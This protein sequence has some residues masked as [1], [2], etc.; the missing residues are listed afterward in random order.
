[1]SSKVQ[2]VCASLSS[3]SLSSG[4]FNVLCLRG[5]T[6]R[7]VSLMFAWINA[8]LWHFHMSDRKESFRST[9][10]DPPNWHFDPQHLHMSHDAGGSCMFHC[11]RRGQGR[12]WAITEQEFPERRRGW[13]KPGKPPESF[14]L[15]A[16]SKRNASS[17]ALISENDLSLIVPL[18]HPPAAERYVDRAQTRARWLSW[19]HIGRVMHPEW[20]PWLIYENHLRGTSAAQKWS[21]HERGDHPYQ[22][23]KLRLLTQT[24]LIEVMQRPW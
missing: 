13:R 7:N 24:W 19:S 15:K 16:K 9:Q 14:V 22:F 20:E 1:M 12:V 6:D 18:D 23:L 17:Y 11:V 2:L 5:P 8:A 4:E 3:R 21:F 10:L